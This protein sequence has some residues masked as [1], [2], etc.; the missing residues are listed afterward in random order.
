M[1][2]VGAKWWRF[3][4]HT[5]TP[6][7]F[8]Y[9]NGDTTN[10]KETISAKAWLQSYIDKGIQCVAIT[11]HNTGEW[12]DR[13]KVEAEQFRKEGKE[14]YIFPGVEITANSNIHIL[15]IFDPSKSTA[16]ISAVVGAAKFR[17]TKGDS[18][19]VAEES[20]E[21]IVDEIIKSG[22]VA[23]PAH[24]DMKAGLCQTVSGHT[25]KQICEKAN[26]VEII[27]PKDPERTV[28]APLTRYN[29][30][31]INLPSVIGSDAHHPSKVGR[32]F[33]WVKMATPSIDGLK[34]A[35]I[36][37]NTS[38]IRSDDIADTT[39]PNISSNLVLKSISIEKSKYA[40]RNQSLNIQFNPWLNCIIGSRGSGKSS[41]LEFIRIGMD[42]SNEL[43]QLKENN[44]IK[45]SFESFL[46]IPLSKESEGIMLNDTYI[47][48]IY[49]KDGVTYSLNWNK[50]DHL[51]KIKKLEGDT[52]IDEAGT[53]YSRF[54]IKIFSQKQIFDLAKDPS[55]LLRFIDE[56]SSVDFQ[57][58]NMDW[59]VKSSHLRALCSQKRELESRVANKNILLGQLLDINQKIQIIESSNHS[60]VFDKYRDLIQKKS[61]LD[62][63]HLQM[64]NFTENSR[65]LTNNLISFD[66]LPSLDINE[67]K[68]ILVTIS[69]MK[70]KFLEFTNSMNVAIFNFEKELERFNQWYPV[71]KFI[72][73]F[74]D[75]QQKYSSVVQT[76]S[77]QGINSFDLY[78]TLVSQRNSINA[79]IEE[80]SDTEKNLLSLTDSI[81]QAYID[82]INKRKEL[83]I[84][85]S[86][87]LNEILKNNTSIKVEILPLCDIEN[88]NDSFRR[89]IG[90]FDAAFSVEI[91]DA[92]RE[93][94]FLY[95]LSQRLNTLGIYQ[96][97][98]NLNNWFNIIHDF[99]N[100]FIKYKSNEILGTKLGK[101]F[102][103]YID[104][105]PME[106]F[107]RLIEWFPEDKLKIKFHDGQKFKDVSQGSAGQKAS[108]VL[109][110]LLSH[111][112]E[113]LILDQP[114]DD[115]DNRLITDLIVSN[116][117][118]TKKNRQIIIVTHNPNIVV[119]GDSEFVV[120]LEDKG[121]IKVMASG[122]LQ[123]INV[124]KHVC[125]IMEGGEMALMQRY[126][127]MIN[128]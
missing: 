72:N 36:D 4:F 68:E 23:I 24:I 127:R 103:D 21:N 3:D 122:A 120:A 125:S 66:N 67:D 117:H 94:G 38:I 65:L 51:V 77:E 90:R 58:W 16:D 15:G 47:K 116:L 114:E 88:L 1:D 28:E 102:T 8:D 76:F 105:Q 126:K 54:P 56:S 50:D 63:L 53:A 20:A 30:Q 93:C 31:N 35:L 110:F 29:N 98:I 52:W 25:I 19:S 42:R 7:S 84:K 86:Q 40:G 124:R 10:L 75:S 64:K 97:Q 33:T 12:I 59:G 106:I 79:S 27:F 9:A 34:L 49:E 108:A 32:A 119:N 101:R 73:D 37:G 45:K 57:Q 2:F 83:T 44:E 60:Q 70:S 95:Q 128:I 115:L 100:E 85:R 18:N 99:K 96:D 62:S 123:E 55:S 89:V 39:N 6:A 92:E 112:S 43:L 118:K 82:L 91:Y 46:K 81:N 41:I 121:Q 109:S 5:H 26:A 104:A 80:I 11:D 13:L 111:G 71:S 107:D 17:G 87:T 69:Y 74:N 61:E 113:P 22:G 78:Q 48:C 14:I